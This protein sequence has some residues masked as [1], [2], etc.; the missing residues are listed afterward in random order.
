VVKAGVGKHS[1]KTTP[2][3]AHLSYL[4]RDGVVLP[5]CSAQQTRALIRGRSLNDVRRPSSFSVDC[6]ARRCCRDE[7]FARLHS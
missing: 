4:W 2:L 6:G 7:G 1:S 3:S 5:A